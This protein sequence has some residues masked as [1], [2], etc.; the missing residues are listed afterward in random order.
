MKKKKKIK[1]MQKN[2]T[3]FK[4]QKAQKQINLSIFCD[5]N[6][7]LN[8]IFLGIDCTFSINLGKLLV[9]IFIDEKLAKYYI[10]WKFI[11]THFQK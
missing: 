3:N 4:T 1:N 6:N 7:E 2:L 10:E 9:W 5:S 8:S 11:I